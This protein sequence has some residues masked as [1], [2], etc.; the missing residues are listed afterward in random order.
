MG[1]RKTKIFTVLKHFDQL[2]VDKICHLLIIFGK[3]I[4]YPKIQANPK[5]TITI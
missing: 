4:P 2:G 3:F 1:A 5:K